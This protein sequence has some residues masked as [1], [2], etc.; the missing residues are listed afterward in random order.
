VLLVAPVLWLFGPALASDRLF[1][2]R[3]ASHFYYPLFEFVQEQWQ[4]GAV[5]LWNPQENLGQP[6][7]ADTTSSV[8]YPGKLLLLL[9]L[10]YDWLYKLYI[11]LHLLAAVLA[12]YFLARKIS[13]SRPAASLAALAYALSGS[14]LVQYANVVFLVGAA[15]LPVAFCFAMRTIDERSPAA[16]VKLACV[17]ALMTLGG[18]PQTAYHAGVLA[19]GYV[20]FRWLAS[21]SVGDQQTE[22]AASQS[23][24]QTRWYRHPIVL[25]G[26][27]AVVAFLLAAVQVLPGAVWARRS[28]RALFEAPRSIYE[29]PQYLAR[30]DSI[31]PADLTP[32]DTLLLGKTEP[33]RHSERS[34]QF[35]VG[36][37]RVAEMIWPNVGGRTFPMNHR[38]PRLFPGDR[39]LWSPTLYFGIVPLFCSLAVFS[40][41]RGATLVRFLS[42]MA[43]FA[44]LA[45]LGRFALGWLFREAAFLIT[46]EPTDA[47]V[48]DGFGGPYWLLTTLLPGYAY[49]RYPA[50]WMVVFVLAVSMLAA[51]GID[52][53]RGSP[54]GS[55]V[56]ALVAL[57]SLILYLAV[58]VGGGWINFSATVVHQAAEADF[59]PLDLVGARFDVLFALGQTAV[60]AAAWWWVVRRGWIK[61]SAFAW[62]AVAVTAADLIAANS[63]LVQ[64]A[65]G[66][67]WETTSP[68]AQAIGQDA[69]QDPQAPPS[70]IYRAPVDGFRPP[71]WPLESSTERQRDIVRWERA[72]LAP[73]YHLP[74][75]I[76]LA[77]SP[78]TMI[79]GDQAA[80]LWL[81]SREA[82]DALGVRYFIGP[83]DWLGEGTQ[84][85]P[86][87]RAHQD[88]SLRHSAVAANQHALP[89][90]WIV[91]LE[92]VARLPPLESRSP[93][94]IYRRTAEVF[95]DG[96]KP[97]DL[98]RT[99]VVES[100]R[101]PQ[102]P[103]I[104]LETQFPR[105]SSA[106]ITG[107]DP[108]RVEIEARLSRPGLL[109]LSDS[110][111]PGW[112]AEVT[113]ASEE[114]PQPV[115]IFRTNRLIRSVP[116]P[117][118]E[119]S[120]VFRYRPWSFYV[121]AVMSVVGWLGV[122]VLAAARFGRR[123]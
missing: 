92:T 10:S 98:R 79:S 109:I 62:A 102:P 70:R 18:D 120:V 71:D 104:S 39:E 63:W 101:S 58:F 119:L 67:L 41:R 33:G 117:P 38:W 77:G 11:V 4:R 82:F 66:R 54:R 34:R 16:A 49:F 3:D 57:V 72:T 2:F 31:Q 80:L 48:G 22:D 113:S 50:K 28:D 122:A 91:D 83:E 8:F 108:S 52:R 121:G 90:T 73:R 85:I 26:F 32:V 93:Q 23:I 44:L 51:F 17:L 59:G 7:A 74:Y 96:D 76:A 64:T 21:R 116:L 123:S 24:R 20:L 114:T 60:L 94:A 36:P 107:Y 35:S 40:L 68:M 47:A 9:P 112:V 95:F 115:P 65:P 46:G 81:N 110:F 103:P 14:V 84:P 100:D 99:A 27:S 43:L 55:L 56:P 37:W 5:P 78:G 69:E 111:A 86:L 89:R 87:P 30:P 29:L 75:D 25:L 1:V 6:L 118:G 12:A 19:V 105:S 42:W 106:R 15:W 97:R 61:L 13:A 45:A 88:R 53:L